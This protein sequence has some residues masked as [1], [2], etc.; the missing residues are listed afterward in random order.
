MKTLC[1]LSF[2]CA[3]AAAPAD[4]NSSPLL[5]EALPGESLCA[6]R[7]R[8]RAI[9]ASNRVHGVEIVLPAGSHTQEKTLELDERDSGA[10]GAP[11]V[12]RAARLPAGR[13]GADEGRLP[14]IVG[15]IDL[16]PSAFRP[17]SDPALLD[18]L[19]PPARG[20]V[21]ETDIS[22]LRFRW[23]N[24]K[25]PPREKGVPMAMPDLF[26]NGRRMAIAT[27]PA[28]G[29]CEM[30]DI[31]DRGTQYGD[32][33]LELAIKEGRVKK[34]EVHGGTFVYAEDRPSRWA[35]N[36]HVAIQAFWRFDWRET[37]ITAKSID[38]AAK[39][40]TLSAPHSFGLGKGNPAPRRWKAINV[41]EELSAPGRYTVDFETRRLYFYPPADFASAGVGVCAAQEPTVRVKG[42]HDIAFDG[43]HFGRSCG[44]ALAVV[45]SSRVVVRRCLF[46]DARDL[47]LR[48]LGSRQTLVRTCDFYR[49]GGG[50]IDLD[51]GERRTLTRGDSSVEDCLF[52]D[53]NGL[54]SAAYAVTARGVGNAIRHCEIRDSTHQA[55]G[56]SGNDCIFEYNVVSNVCTGTDDCGAFYKGRDP[57]KRGN[58][59]R[60][61]YF[62]RIGRRDVDRAH[63]ASSVY[64]DDG[65]G[66]DLVFGNVFEDASVAGFGNFGAVFSHGGYSN[67]VRNC[68]F[69]DCSRP[70][71]SSP[72]SQ[73]R[74]SSVLKT[75]D[76]PDSTW[77]RRNLLMV[78]DITKPPFT[79]HYPELVGFMDPQP[80]EIRW[81][82]AYD[83][84]FVDCPLLLPDAKG[85]L[86]KPGLVAGRWYTNETTVAFSGDPG[87]ADRAA[88]DLRLRADSEIYRKI[89]GFKPIPFEKIGLLTRE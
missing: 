36:P 9:P 81:N 62:R 77:L 87:F 59:L 21:L 5:I 57:S 88:H 84:A 16:P 42:A 7:D 64:F 26:V 46:T 32:R 50:G 67:V 45:N 51:D 71:G 47:A 2:L 72:W 86:T 25:A 65:D 28:Q 74:W 44:Y 33:S 73:E 34:E 24:L 27:F 38:P 79:T 53:W 12:W 82:A 37:V 4:A 14:L 20:K 80:D 75:G 40:I 83:N 15:G 30:V 19:D 68:I 60:Y 41:F 11:V 29:W 39:T 56:T 43:L 85:K 63:G 35:A 8:V 10:P 78:V 48:T 54:K 49:L 1:T 52:H 18:R 76:T 69:L 61:N 23:P 70:L 6:V 58:V 17:V 3:V 66:G 31:L 22:N 55:A 13:P 89:P